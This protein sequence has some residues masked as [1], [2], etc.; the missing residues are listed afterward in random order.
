MLAGAAAVLRAKR[1]VGRAVGARNARAK[2]V[3]PWEARMLGLSNTSRRT[4]GLGA[5]GAALFLLAAPAGAEDVT[6]AQILRALSPPKTRSLSL[7]PATV[8]PS[9]DGAF[10]DSLRNKDSHAL[11]EAERRKLDSVAASKPAIDLT[12]EFDYNSDVLRGP[13]LAT[14]GKLGKALSSPELKGQTFVIA[15]HTDAKGADLVNQRLSERRADAVKRYLVQTH[16][17]PAANL[18]SVGYGKGHLKNPQAPMSGENR[19]VQAVNMLQSKTA[20][21]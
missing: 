15:G 9:P 18:I 10:V 6:E 5:L 19:R 20:S 17:I 3:H 16:G 11:S 7:G 12:M 8:E 2:R 4:V 21:R 14:A 13:A 1:R